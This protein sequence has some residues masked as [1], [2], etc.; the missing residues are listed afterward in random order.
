MRALE[1]VNRAG[2]DLQH[3]ANVWD[4]D[5][6]DRNGN[7]QL[8]TNLLSKIDLAEKDLKATILV[9]SAYCVRTRCK[10]ECDFS[11]N[12]KLSVRGFLI[13][14]YLTYF[15][16]VATVWISCGGGVNMYSVY[17]ML[18]NSDVQMCFYFWEWGEVAVMDPV[19][20]PSDQL[21]VFLLCRLLVLT[22]L[23]WIFNS[24]LL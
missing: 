15:W 4:F 12:G 17:I 7:L 22:P 20:T 18:H 3:Q 21:V 10:Y 1:S 14:S 11:N 9:L 13:Q 19:I 6:S 24:L 16:S 2:G 8:D 5:L 23:C